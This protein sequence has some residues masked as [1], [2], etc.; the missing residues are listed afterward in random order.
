[1]ADNTERRVSLYGL[2]QAVLILLGPS[3]VVYTNQ[4]GGGACT[5]PAEQG[6]L[7]PLS[8]D[9]PLD[10]S[11]PPLEIRLRQITEGATSLS[12]EQADALDAL[13]AESPLTSFV[14]VDRRRLREASEAWVYV[15]IT[16]EAEHPWSGLEAD[17]GVMSWPNSD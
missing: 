11:R 3:G 7:V 2:E 9:P 1:M 15:Q 13:L 16:Q 5:Q 4:A 6:W 8:D 14:S 17:T 10:G 12:A